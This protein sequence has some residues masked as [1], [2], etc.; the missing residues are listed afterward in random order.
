MQFFKKIKTKDQTHTITNAE[1][2]KA[3]LDKMQKLLQSKKKQLVE[4]SDI[5]QNVKKL[6]ANYLPDKGLISRL[7][8]Q[9]KKT[10]VDNLS[11]KK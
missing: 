6:F 2:T 8:Q 10:I 4:K 9:L 3:K 5:W 1:S 7:Y 11:V